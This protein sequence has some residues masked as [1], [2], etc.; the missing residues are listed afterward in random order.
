MFVDPGRSYDLIGDVHG[1]AQALERLLSLLG[2]RKEGGVWRHARRMTLFLGDLVDRGPQIREAL[3]L[4]R[5]MVDA[6][7]ALCLMGNH[8]F[9]ALGW[10]TALSDVPGRHYVREHSARN[11]RVIEQTL[12]QFE[13][14]PEDWR[15]FLDWFLQL[16]LLL[17]GDRFRVVHA[18]WDFDIIAR[19]RAQF[20]DARIDRAFLLRSGL[21]RTFA[22]RACD[23]LL[24][25]MAL[26]LPDGLSM[27]GLD[28][29]VRRNF[30]TRFWQGG[31]SETYGDVLF[32]PDPLPAAIARMPLDEAERK[33]L[34]I[35]GDDEPLLFVGHYWRNG[36][37]MPERPNVA[38][39]DY[40]AVING[41]LAAYRL[42]QETVLDPEK[43][44]WVDNKVTA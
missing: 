5:D 43:F 28:G 44:V 8:E 10:T 37:P 1:C 27:R 32:Q 33:R 24:T 20:A 40:S 17:D 38:C 19:L 31:P 29:Y 41:K 6:G 14:Y 3:H 11:A 15:S 23:R 2:Y 36:I 42:D 18:C 21:P 35:Y 39:L 9:N 12:A 4:V 22:H 30:R 25:G 7:Q 13:A 16:P 34:L 26:R